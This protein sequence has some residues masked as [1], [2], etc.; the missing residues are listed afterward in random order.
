MWSGIIILTSLLRKTL[1][2]KKINAQLPN[3]SIQRFLSFFVLLETILFMS[4]CT[5]QVASVSSEA[6]PYGQVTSVPLGLPKLRPTSGPTHGG[7]EEHLLWLKANYDKSEHMIP[8]RDGVELYTLVYM[9]KNWSEDVPI[10]LFRTPYSIG[11]YEPEEYRNPLGPS[12]EFDRAGYIFVF[13]DVRG[14]FKSGGEFEVIRPL[15]L[16]PKGPMDVDES[17]DNYDTIDWL[18]NNIEGH[19]SLAGQWGI[20][21]SGW[22]TA[23]GMVDAHPALVASSPQASPS[24][25]F[26]GDDFHHNG[27]FRITYAFQWLAGHARTRDVPT[28]QRVGP[29]DY[30]T[31]WGYEFFM[32]A[33]SASNIDALYFQGDVPAWQEFMEHDTYD[34][35]WKRQ[36]ALQY[37]DG[38]DHA[39]LN[40]AGW[41]DTEDFYGPMSIYR[42]VEER[43]PNSENTLVVG[44]WLHGGWRRMWG[45]HL[46]CIDFDSQTS[47]Y[48]QTKVQF[49][50]FEH[51]LRGG[52]DWTPHEAIVFNTGANVW[53]THD[54]WPPKNVLE[55][56]IYLREESKLSFDPPTSQDTQLGDSW[57]SDPNKPVPFSA[58]IRTTLGHL[59]KVED[60]RFA[61]TR[62][63][64]MVYVSDILEE[65][66]TVVGPI[67]ADI[68]VSTT[69]TDSDWAVK[70]I[71]V[72]PGDAPSSV[73]CD[74]PMGGYQMHLAG[75]IMRGRFRNSFEEPEPMVPE[76]V[77]PIQIDLR[78]R[79]HTFKAGHQIM[80]HIQSSWFPAYDRNPQKFV[81]T[82]RAQPDDYEIATQTV[83][84]S[85]QYPSHLTLGVVH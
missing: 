15:A 57:V 49:P 54:T 11:P 65:D 78:D 28:E 44:P 77:T 21:Y 71:D 6:R 81:D 10:L 74:I 58:E 30:G 12:V 83:F 64:V 47:V 13:Q 39:I 26:I 48:F 31:P 56:K 18:I 33:G 24:N 45:D 75:E 17:T 35:Y 2:M 29:F 27:A 85:S 32:E 63:D 4:G 14:K 9:P 42:T 7:T 22:Q 53:E 52:Q 3:E 50:F 36:D 82:Y 66:L 46:G 16:Q 20:S 51:H 19:N 80:V 69:G 62:P 60:Q 23:M 73:S 38:I 25:M 84:R 37:L 40:V 61:S 5:G 59:W 79:Y 70:L 76:Q 72:Y 1:K 43:N 34:E 55:K 68:W 8:M 41:F 67:L